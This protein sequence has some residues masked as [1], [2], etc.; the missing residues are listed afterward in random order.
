MFV[1]SP[2][3]SSCHHHLI[4]AE[5][6]IRRGTAPSEHK[7]I[8]IIIAALYKNPCLTREDMSFTQMSH[9]LEARFL[10]YL[11]CQMIRMGNPFL[12]PHE[13]LCLIVWIFGF[14]RLLQ[15]SWSTA[16]LCRMSFRFSGLKPFR[17]VETRS[18]TWKFILY[19]TETC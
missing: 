4:S 1:S 19:L 5:T 17:A 18:T 9:L 10:I 14:S 13:D 2:S 16:L 8:V 7:S 3:L 11:P 15:L 12:C 6:P